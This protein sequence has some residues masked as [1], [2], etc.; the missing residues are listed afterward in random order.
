QLNTRHCTLAFYESCYTTE[1]LPMVRRPQTGIIWRDASLGGNGCSLNHNEG[2]STNGTAPK[3][4]KMPIIGH[5][6]PTGILAHWRY[7]YSI[8]EFYFSQTESG[9]EHAHG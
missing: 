6:I 1:C 7:E 2:C 4:N 5:S 9:K 3:V 8:S